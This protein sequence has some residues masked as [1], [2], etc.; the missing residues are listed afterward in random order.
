MLSVASRTIILSVMLSA[1]M[2]SVIMLSVIMLSVIMLS[3]IMLSVVVPDR[4]NRLVR[5]KHSLAYTRRGH[6]KIMAPLSANVNVL[7]AFRHL[8]A[9]WYHANVTLGQKAESGKWSC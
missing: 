9:C 5:S 3:A 1:I 4:L 2:L 8:P 7:S 6:G